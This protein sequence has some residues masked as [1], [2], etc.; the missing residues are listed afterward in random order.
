MEEGGVGFGI[1]RVGRAA[2]VSI[3]VGRRGGGR[4]EDGKL[5]VSSLLLLL[6]LVMMVLLQLL[7]LLLLLLK[8]LR[9]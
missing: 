1:G 4:L 8:I 2:I 9:W 3:P 5:S 7:V 6:L